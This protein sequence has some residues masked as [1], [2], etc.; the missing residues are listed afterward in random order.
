M[1]KNSK[2]PRHSNVVEMSNDWQQVGG[3]L[4]QMMS[5]LQVVPADQTSK[6]PSLEDKRRLQQA[7]YATRKAA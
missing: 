7:R 4:G 2:T 3:A 6:R 5:R 1:M